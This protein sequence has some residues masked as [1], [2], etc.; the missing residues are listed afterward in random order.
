MKT[1]LSSLAVAS[2]LAC[3]L[4]AGCSSGEKEALT[5]GSMS[6]STKKSE[7]LKELR[8]ALVPSDDAEQMIGQF[9]KL[10]AFLEKDLGIPVSVAKV[11]SYAACIEAMKKSHVDVAWYGPTSYILAEQEANAEAFMVSAD[12][13]G[14]TS[15]FSEFL[16]PAASTA[17]SLQD[18]KE[19]RVG[20]V[21]ASS[22]SGGLIPSFMVLSATS[23]PIDQFCKVSYLGNHDAVVNAVKESAVD[24]GA[25]NNLTVER[26]IEQKKL[27]ESDF[28]VIAKSDPLP[29]SPLAWRK[30][31]PDDF[32][33]KLKDSLKRSAA[34][35]G[36]YKVA[37]FG[38][39]ATFKEVKPDDYKMI[40]DI[41]AKLHLTR[42]E[43]LK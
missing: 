10:R 22:T 19:K 9:E 35:L 37:G 4:L 32:K 12:T 38:E 42:E 36:V 33:T 27:K 21:E 17:K 16:V 7:P 24:A 1:L 26:L 5:Q 39:I 6:T 31:L 41:A 40:R 18:L 11:T 15:Y 25:T 13:K 2:A 29:G 23:T 28:K 30:D 34:S 20:L 43:L 14:V 3:G 8:I